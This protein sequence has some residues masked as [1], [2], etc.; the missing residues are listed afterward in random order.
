MA[1]RTHAPI[2]CLRCSPQR[3][4]LTS[5]LSL[6]LALPA[7]AGNLTG[8][9]SHTVTNSDVK[10]DWLIEQASHL[11]LAPGA[12]AGS[13]SLF[14]QST[15]VATDASLSGSTGSV[16]LQLVNSNA[17]LTRTT[18]KN[19]SGIGLS[20]G[21]DT[22]ITTLPPS[23]LSIDTG[24]IEGAGTAVHVSNGGHVVAS[25]T[26]FV[27]TFDRSRPAA[28]DNGTALH[29]E[30]ADVHLS[31]SALRGDLNGVLIASRE[32]TRTDVPTVFWAYQTRIEGTSGSSIVVAPSP[33][34]LGNSLILR[35]VDLIAGNGILIDVQ[36]N[37][38]PRASGASTAISIGESNLAGDIRVAPGE[39]AT[40][41]LRDV[42]TLRGDISGDV[43]LYMEA[44]GSWQLARS[45]RIS[46]LNFYG[47]NTVELGAGG[48]F[49]TLDV[50]GDFQGRISSLGSIGT[51]VF[52]TALAGDDSP[53]DRLIIGGS[54]TGSAN[55][56][57]RNVGGGGAQTSKGI[58]LITVRGTSAA[59]FNLLGR[60]VAGQYEYFLHKGNGTDGNWYL[61]SQLPVQPEPCELDPS[62]PQCN[63]QQVLRPEVGAYLSNLQA[64][65]TLFRSG[66]HD[67]HAGQNA[68]R[69][70]VR[71]SGSRQGFDAIARQLDIR[72]NSQSLTVG[73]DVW[74]ADAGSIGV[75]LSAG[76]ATSTSTNEL[77]GY[78]ARGKVKGEM[79]GLYG[80]WR[81]SESDE[82]YAGF[83]VD[84]SLQRAQFRNRVEGIGL[85]TERYEARAW[86]SAIE[87]GYTFRIAGN[88]SRS[89][90]L[91]PSLQIGY[92][93]W[94]NEGHTEANGT[95]VRTLGAN[96]V[97][98]HVGLR[99]SGVTR[100]G[101]AAAVVQPYIAAN[102]LH[103]RARSQILMGDEL[104][105]ARIPRSRGEITAGASM[106]F[107]S[108]IGAWAG[109]TVQKSGGYHQTSAQLG[110]NYTW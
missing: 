13:V 46:G 103:D 97:F 1:T 47:R 34:I 29:L 40:V 22:A 81:R 92:N 28:D 98:G 30:K 74:R 62:L 15:L 11:T 91:E 39:T 107:A 104:A 8:G 110:I 88:D 57:V 5:A 87:S 6:C 85:D 102:W 84:G 25:N 76:N 101:G 86:Q 55:V 10:E 12:S 109:M 49:H 83:Y 96:G 99:L 68:G 72:G 67:R 42:T 100:W 35:K 73:T 59:T 3:A 58:E 82:P 95:V 14:G 41:T 106:K 50:K 36:A 93:R 65:Q 105:N 20:L 48:D 52:N 108:G 90:Y 26:K 51:I 45:A 64:A 18:V 80:T 9:A 56:E 79:L 69:A 89:V 63:P 71:A 31:D 23:R 43:A 27:A 75:Q 60:T 54:T 37:S 61:R 24:N 70:W 78:Y 66:Y 32:T 53:T 77:S 94:D 33:D 19:A 21:A 16:L 7:F 2:S 17:T 4:A 38:S 44:G